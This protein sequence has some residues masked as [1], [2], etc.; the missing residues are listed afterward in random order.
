MWALS[1][2]GT[3]ASVDLTVA[4]AGGT[5]AKSSADQFTFS[6]PPAVTAVSPAS[7]PATGGTTVTITGSGFTGA[8]E[9]DFFAEG[10]LSAVA[11]SDLQVLSDNELTVTIPPD[12]SGSNGG[13][14]ADITVTT[15]AGTSATSPADEFSCIAPIATT[16]QVTSSA[17]PSIF[18]QLLTFTATV[19]SAS[20]TF[21]GGGTVQFGLDGTAIGPPATLS[22]GVATITD[23][24]VDVGTH[25]VTA[26]YSGDPGFGTSGG[27]LS[28]GQTVNPAPVLTVSTSTLTLPA[29]TQG[30]AGATASFTI[31]GSGPGSGDSV[32][33][34]AP[35]G[36]EISAS[37]TSGFG[38]TLSL[39]PSSSGVLA[40]TTVYTRISASATANVSGDL[41]ITDALH[42]SLSRSIPVKGTVTSADAIVAAPN[43]NV[44]TGSAAAAQ[45][46]D[47]TNVDVPG[48]TA[49]PTVVL[50][51]QTL[52]SN[53]AANATDTARAQFNAFSALAA[54]SVT[55]AKT[56][57][58]AAV[59]T[60]AVKTAVDQAIRELTASL[61]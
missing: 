39:D 34:A 45:R 12:P 57:P 37:S 31:S 4:T 27:G 3:L 58:Q 49:S 13:D 22:D 36:C 44:G 23:S 32:T 11:G 46:V 14:W 6:A 41:T 43:Q 42:S 17:D 54:S 29:T 16:T 10:A 15:S 30:T 8:T 26:L 50:A 35:T 9:V 61:G 38:G 52:A 40:T 59:K 53:Q 55:T 7:G 28:G 33:L 2:P 5:S 21:D 24:A 51:G 47:A 1:P 25:T 20:G 18:G 60:S 48:T 19:T 56:T